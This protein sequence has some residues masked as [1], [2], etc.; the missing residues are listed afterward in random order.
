[1]NAKEAREQ[2]SKNLPKFLK[3]E[4]ELHNKLVKSLYF[5]FK[6][7]IN[8]KVK[9]CEY[10]LTEYLYNYEIINNNVISDTLYLLRKEGFVVDTN[11]SL[12]SGL[13]IKISWE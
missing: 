10:K 2:V 4:I 8:S 13:K 5:R 3:K 9:I 1:M 11:P 7:N 12:F 6:A